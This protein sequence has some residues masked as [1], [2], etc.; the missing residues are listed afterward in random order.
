MYF[1]P[2]TEK[3]LLSIKCKLTGFQLIDRFP[4]VQVAFARATAVSIMHPQP[5]HVDTMVRA[6]ESLHTKKGEG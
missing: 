5:T 1:S 4:V 2:Q 6:D 3:S